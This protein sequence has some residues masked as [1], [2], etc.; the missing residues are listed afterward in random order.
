MELTTAMQDMLTECACLPGCLGYCLTALMKYPGQNNVR[1]KK[2]I[3]AHSI[4]AQ[5][6]GDFIVAGA[7]DSW[8]HRT[9]SR[10]AECDERTLGLLSPY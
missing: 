2:F 7:C 10:E 8:S 9:H 4:E 3:L 1:E 6:G 5:R